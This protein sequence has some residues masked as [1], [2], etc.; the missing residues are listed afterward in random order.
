MKSLRG[1]FKIHKLRSGFVDHRK[2][3]KKD[4]DKIGQPPSKFYTEDREYLRKKVIQ[5]GIF[6]EEE[7]VKIEKE[8]C[9]RITG[10]GMVKF[11][12][13]GYRNMLIKTFSP[14][15]I[16]GLKLMMKAVA[17]D[18]GRLIIPEKINSINEIEENIQRSPNIFLNQIKNRYP[19]GFNE[20][21]WKDKY[22]IKKSDSY[23]PGKNGNL[24][25]EIE[26]LI[27]LYRFIDRPETEEKKYVIINHADVNHLFKANI[28]T[29]AGK[30]IEDID[31][32]GEYII[33]DGLLSGRAIRNPGELK[34]GDFSNL[35]ILK[36]C[37][38]E[39]VGCTGCGK[40]INVCP[41]YLD[42]THIIKVFDEDKGFIPFSMING[43]VGCGLC[44]YLCPGWKLE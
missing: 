10:N 37:E 1:K 17:A 5:S 41:Q 35:I 30:L 4:K 36:D 3:N 2:K 8:G 11:P 22:G 26:K 7:I 20:I 29:N 34:A 39:L 9:G 40:C 18:Y 31:G 28:S 33:K 12:F 25:V 6:K 15:I 14:Q 38:Y 24:V 32:T 21:L 13:V 43:C 23:F 27:K 19:L 16:K 44:G 42:T